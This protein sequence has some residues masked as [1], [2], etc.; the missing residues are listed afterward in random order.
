VIKIIFRNILRSESSFFK[1]KQIESKKNGLPNSDGC[2]ENELKQN[3]PLVP[4][5]V[6]PKIK[7]DRRRKYENRINGK[8]IFLSFWKSV[9][10]TRCI[11]VVPMQSHTNCFP[12]NLNGA[13]V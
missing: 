7:T 3:Q 5:I 12:A 10:E 2:K 11:T 4:F 13:F 6:D 8:N 1:K 9:I